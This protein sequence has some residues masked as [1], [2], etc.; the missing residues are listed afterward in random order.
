MEFIDIARGIA[1]ILMIVG[2]VVKFNG[3]VW[4]I[5]Y[6]FHMPLFIICSGYFF[7]KE[8]KLSECIK[9]VIKKLILPYVICCLFV[10]I[11]L[12]FLESNYSLAQAIKDWI[13]QIIS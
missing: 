2:H 6:S 5:I 8:E 9:K 4:R 12:I 10:N 3:L 1:I 7:K 11:V 13:K